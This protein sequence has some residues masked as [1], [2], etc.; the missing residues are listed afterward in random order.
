MTEKENMIAELHDVDKENAKQQAK[1]SRTVGED[2][3][4]VSTW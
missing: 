3:W 1:S 2:R 4:A